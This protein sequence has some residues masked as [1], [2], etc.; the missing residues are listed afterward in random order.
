MEHKI[1]RPDRT[2]C[3]SDSLAF[4]QILPPG[5]GI[6]TLIDYGSGPGYHSL[7]LK[8]LGYKVT[9][10]DYV[11]PAYPEL[12]WLYP[13]ETGQLQPV[14]AIWSHHCLEHVA[15][16]IALLI[17]WQKLLKPEGDL[18][19]TIPPVES[20]M[21]AGHIT[22]YTPAL[23]LYHLAIAGFDCSDSRFCVE[24]FH[25]QGGAHLRAWV[26]KSLYHP[27]SYA[28][29]DGVLLPFLAAQNLFPPEVAL[30]VKQTRKAF[31]ARDL[32]CRWPGYNPVPVYEYYL[33]A[34]GMA[35]GQREDVRKIPPPIMRPHFSVTLH[36]HYYEENMPNDVYIDEMVTQAKRIG[37]TLKPISDGRKNIAAFF[38]CDRQYVKYLGVALTSLAKNASPESTYDLIVLQTD[39]QEEDEALLAG[40][41][42]DYPNISLRSVSLKECFSSHPDGERLFPTRAHFTPATY[43]RLLA[44]LI[45]THYSKIVYLDSD[46]IILHDI[47]LL[48][49]IDLGN[50]LL[51]AC[52]DLLAMIAYN[53]NPKFKKFYHEILEFR[54]EDLFGYFNGAMLVMNLRQM[55]ED[56]TFGK[57]R[58]AL[59]KIKQPHFVD[60]DILNYS[61]H[62]RVHYIDTSWNDARWC[63][64]VYGHIKYANVLPPH[65]YEAFINSLKSP[66]K[67][68][69]FSSDI[70]PWFSSEPNDARYFWRYARLTPY[71]EVLLKEMFTKQQIDWENKLQERLRK[72]AEP[73]TEEQIFN[74]S[75]SIL[76]DAL[77]GRKLFWAHQFYRLMALVSFKK[78]SKDRYIAKR[79]NYAN[80]RKAVKRF[81][82]K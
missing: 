43:Y 13:D 59:E 48:Y 45:F 80:R 10:V 33:E 38:G 47:A 20:G 65:I 46:M 75:Q 53:R 44:P 34:I 78:S 8:A 21:V 76:F 18:F 57:F 37:D 16:P 69:H 11:K 26:R 6:K 82:Q 62:G 61:L 73:R 19:L 74:I 30:R 81:F 15:N 7:V 35:C 22:A 70:K 39:F 32:I 9:C 64:K 3:F 4:L 77:N 24:N 28:D 31:L 71:Y 58:E 79:R 1:L 60:Q 66:P 54:E 55:R 56:D 14:D 41:L 25:T 23:L 36:H 40:C 51:G 5:N 2:R 68:L 63:A 52:R 72:A 27:N 12:D 29:A 50:A 67:I 49:E 42:V 17:Q